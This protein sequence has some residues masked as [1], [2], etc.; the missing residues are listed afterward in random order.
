MNSASDDLDA[1]AREARD[2]ALRVLG[3]AQAGFGAASVDASFRRY[4]RVQAPDGRSWVLMDAPPERENCEPFIR[5][6]MLLHAAG[7]HVPQVLAQ[8]L[9]RG[10]LLLTDLGRQTYLHVIDADNAHALFSDAIEALVR[11]QGASQPGV[12]PEYDRALLEREL[13]L[14]PEWFVARHLNRRFDAAQQAEWDATC[15]LLLD[16][17]LTQPRVYVHR[18]YMPRNLMRST[19]NPGVLDFQDAVHGPVTYDVVCLF[20]DAFLSWPEARVQAWVA[21]YRARAAQA[22]VPQPQ[23]FERAF[24]W[25]GVQRHLKVLGIFARIRYRDGKPHYLED[26]PRFVRYVREVA[27][28]HAQ[29]APLLRLFDSLGLHE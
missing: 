2:W 23:D 7:L 26:A 15:A 28:R 18:D 22:G 19:P 12:L 24:D 17:A 8:D 11:L 25:M 27:V 16:S 14:F 1:R 29:L 10:F 5:I 13:A 20:K 3:L 9:S 6:A 4:F 21:Q